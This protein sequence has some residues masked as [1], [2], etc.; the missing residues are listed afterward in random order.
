MGSGG[1]V[2]VRDLEDRL[3]LLTGFAG[4]I[5]FEFDRDGTYR[6]VWAGEPALLAKPTSELIGRN[7]VDVLGSEAKTFVDILR[8]VADSGA[9][10]THVYV[11]DVPAGRRTFRSE[12]RRKP[13]DDSRVLFFVRDVTQETELQAK[14]VHA[15]RLAA[16]GLLAASVGHEIRQPLAYATT[17]VE[18]L[19]RELGANG[20]A[21]A[22]EALS[23][24]ED[25]LERIHQ[26]A[27]S[28]GVVAADRPRETTTRDLR[29][30]LDAALDLCASELGPVEVDAELP[31][32]PAVKGN[33]GELCQVFSN[34]LLNAVQA[35]DAARERKISVRADHD[36]DFVRVVLKD[37]G[38]GIRP[39]VL[40]RVFD[41]FFTTKAE[42]RG[43]GLGLFVCRRIVRDFGGDVTVS[44]T[45]GEGTAVVVSL[46]RSERAPSVP[47]PKAEESPARMSLLVVDDEPTFLRSLELLL[48]DVHEVVVT[49][50]SRQALAMVKAEPERF[51]AILCDLAMPEIDG[52][53]FYAEAKRLGIANRFVLMT[54]GAKT[55]RMKPFAEGGSCFTL[56]KPFASDELDAMLS[57]IGRHSQTTS[58]TV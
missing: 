42:G 32:L 50:C 47:I 49:K 23:H 46:R 3:E 31:E 54:G 21:R 35:M 45:P 5:L 17:S 33:E 40:D 25:A 51:D 10:E 8:R 44:S 53:S 9:Q 20:S 26:I 37:T 57:R 36:A 38:A 55:Q 2:T 28:I 7:L 13:G 24:V 18:V 16:I 19:S 27:S 12:A 22:R 56:A 14:L 15:E 29:R 4:G 52:A 34:L 6:R 39:E 41:A 11:M 48:G 58:T 30:A 43:T 1:D